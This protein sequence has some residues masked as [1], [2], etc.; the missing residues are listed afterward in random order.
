MRRAPKITLSEKVCTGRGKSA[1]S[2]HRSDTSLRS[3]EQILSTVAHE[4]CHRKL[5][6]AGKG[7]VTIAHTA[8]SGRMDHQ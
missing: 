4:M 5:G 8:L 6:S 7:Q 3:T 1:T 2:G